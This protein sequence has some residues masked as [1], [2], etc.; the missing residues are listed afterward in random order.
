[1]D[2]DKKRQAVTDSRLQ[3]SFDD[4]PM[5]PLRVICQA[6]LQAVLPPLS[7]TILSAKLLIVEQPSS[8]GFDTQVSSS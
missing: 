2:T 4:F 7:A 5:I 1:M 3:S 8:G 6:R